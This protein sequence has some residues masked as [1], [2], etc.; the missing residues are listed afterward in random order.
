VLAVVVSVVLSMAQV[1]DLCAV[2]AGAHAM[3]TWFALADGA[4]SKQAAGGWVVCKLWLLGWGSEV[5]QLQG[6]CRN[7]LQEVPVHN[8]LLS[9]AGG[10]LGSGVCS[11]L[12]LAFSTTCYS[13]LCLQ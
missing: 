4:C 13:V 9:I 6:C 10:C 2:L 8:A 3:C 1:Q 5:Q 7:W 11:H 12:M